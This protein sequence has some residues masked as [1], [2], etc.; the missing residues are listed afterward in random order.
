[1]KA[2]S[3]IAAWLCCT[4]SAWEWATTIV[5]LALLCTM[6]S[7]M[8][9]KNKMRERKR[10]LEIKERRGKIWKINGEE[11]WGKAKWQRC[12]ASP[13]SLTQHLAQGIY[14]FTTRG[15]RAWA[16][17]SVLGSLVLHTLWPSRYKVFFLLFRISPVAFASVVLFLITRE[18]MLVHDI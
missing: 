9:C 2:S 16:G 7:H 18:N 5:L 14:Y 10:N 11:R 17:S 6:F 3:F 13:S 1:M 15:S 12:A 8:Q 4:K